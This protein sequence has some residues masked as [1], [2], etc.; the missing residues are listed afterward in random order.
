MRRIEA[1]RTL[2]GESD[3]RID[4]VQYGPAPALPRYLPIES[5]ASNWRRR[6]ALGAPVHVP[7]THVLGHTVRC[8]NA[9]KLQWLYCPI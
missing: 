2:G 9:L 5:S 1:S 4:I 3:K 7:S 8:H 6:S